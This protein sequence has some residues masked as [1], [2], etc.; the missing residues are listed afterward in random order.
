MEDE[1]RSLCLNLTYLLTASAT[2]QNIRHQ[3]SFRKYFL[4]LYYVHRNALLP[5]SNVCSQ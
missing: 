2:P 3:H 5:V 4:S 1:E